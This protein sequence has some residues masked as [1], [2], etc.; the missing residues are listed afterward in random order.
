MIRF[1]FKFGTISEWGYLRRKTN[2]VSRKK[3]I[4]SMSVFERVHTPD[5]LR[6]TLHENNK[7]KIQAIL[8]ARVLHS[9]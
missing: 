8:R 5:M 4:H 7:F 6:F 3:S 9:S 2:E 1:S